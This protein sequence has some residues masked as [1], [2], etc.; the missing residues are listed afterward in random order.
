[1]FVTGYGERSLNEPYR[2]HPALQKPFQLE[3][4]KAALDKLLV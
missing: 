3:Q 1:V 2:D 4:L